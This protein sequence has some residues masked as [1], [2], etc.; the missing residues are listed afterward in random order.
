MKY[1]KYYENINTK[2]WNNCIDKTLSKIS[3]HDL[4]YGIDIPSYYNNISDEDMLS[5][6]GTADKEL[7][8]FISSLKHGRILWENYIHKYSYE[9]WTIMKSELIT[10]LETLKKD[11]FM[12]EILESYHKKMGN[13]DD[14]IERI[15][16]NSPIY[17]NKESELYE[18][19]EKNIKNYLLEKIKETPEI[20]TKNSEY[21]DTYMKDNIP[22]WI[23]NTRKYNL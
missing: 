21:F 4:I 13:Y 5:G 9:F 11:P 15:L 6:Y 23:K 10:K 8:H 19:V 17:K 12:S 2:T 18:K 16:N 7:H 1:I 20:Y 22:D 3:I 14:I